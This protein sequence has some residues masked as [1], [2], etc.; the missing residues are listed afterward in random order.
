[1]KK[2][3]LMMALAFT[4]SAF[5]QTKWIKV[6]SRVSG[7]MLTFSLYQ[8]Q[9]DNSYLEIQSKEEDSGIWTFDSLASGIYRVHVFIGYTKYLPTWHPMKVIWDEAADIDITSADSFVCDEGL[10]PNPAIT[11]PG[12]ISGGLTEGMLKTAGDPLRNTR[13]VIVDNNNAFVKMGSTN[14]S[15]TFSINNLPVG[16]YKIKVDVINASTANPKTVVLDSTN[17]TATVDL[18]VNS[19]GTFN[20]G[21]SSVRNTSKVTLYPNPFNDLI[22][23]AGTKEYRMDIYDLNGKKVKH[24]EVSGTHGATVADLPAGIYIIEL[25]S[26][27]HS[28][29]VIQKMI[30]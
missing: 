15:G 6:N 11:G 1:M 29:T 25:E 9:A 19:G 12:S 5:A 20:T 30:K 16:T 23:V 21:L 26:M 14:D 13:V 28:E 8:K 7:T 17:L 4:F 18:T 27:D 3:L 2:L 22:M 10:V 24:A